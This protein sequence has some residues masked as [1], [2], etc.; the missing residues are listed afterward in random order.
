MTSLDLDDLARPPKNGTTWLRKVVRLLGPLAPYWIS[1]QQLT[2]ARRVNELRRQLG[3]SA[4]QLDLSPGSCRILF[5]VEDTRLLDLMEPAVIFPVKWISCESDG[6][7]QHTPEH[8]HRLPAGLQLVAKRVKA[9]LA[10]TSRQGKRASN[11]Y[12]SFP[13]PNREWPDISKFSE[14]EDDCESAFGA[15]LIGL[16]SA[17]YGQQ[18]F[19][20]QWISVAWEYGPKKVTRLDDK[21]KACLLYT[22]PRPRD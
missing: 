1:E 8:D 16:M 3:E 13:E 2:R 19:P 21:L 22:S 5:A 12:L 18:T 4:P 6:T 20:K 7:N 10:T 14:K 11:F 9:L 15:L 17:L